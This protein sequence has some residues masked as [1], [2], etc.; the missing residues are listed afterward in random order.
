MGRRRQENLAMMSDLKAWGSDLAFL[1]TLVGE[2]RYRV[3]LVTPDT[4]VDGKSEIKGEDLDKKIAAFRKAVQDSRV[5][6]R[7]L[8]KEL[9][10]I[11]VKP[12][13]KQLDGAR[14]KT[15]L[16]SLD[17]NLRLL[18]LAALWDGKQFFGQKYQ[19]VVVTLASRT[20]L[21][22]A[23]KP[24]SR[25]LGVGVSEP[26]KVKEPNGIR[27]I[28][29]VGLPGVKDELFSIVRE[30]ET[31]KGV[32]PG[33]RLINAE[34]SQKTLSDELVKRYP[35][36]HIASHFSM[37][38]GD[39]TKSFL[40][41]G[42]GQPLTVD[43]I[44]NDPRLT[45]NGVELLALSACQ[46]AVVEKDTNGK[47]I[48]GFG[49]VAQQKGAKSILAT[50]WAVVDESTQMLMTE[51][52]RLRKE[53]PAM[54]KSA[55]LQAAQRSMIEGRLKPTGVSQACRGA[56]P[57]GSPAEFKCDVNAPFSHPYFW[58]PFVLIGNWR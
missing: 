36:V 16:W 32:L 33:E 40:L 45:F 17:G 5:D 4:Q 41:L 25:V 18:P 12:I 50:L 28:D 47:E 53:N 7:P 6:P 26:R 3:I 13:E 55:A 19:N 31:E 54:S 21:G 46:T 39:S 52:Y 44:K 42:D 43:Q 51:F 8:G 35:V 9:Y 49:Y 2:G 1:Y 38:P 24:S 37:N 27:E 58:S 56:K 22:D 57:V 10:D 23:A 15:L 14:S 29:F 48:E 30:S 20:R 11:I 34:F